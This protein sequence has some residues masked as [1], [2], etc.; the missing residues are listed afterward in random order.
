MNIVDRLTNRTETAEP[1][2]NRARRDM[3]FSRLRTEHP[4]WG[5]ENIDLSEVDFSLTDDE[6]RAEI[7][8]HLDITA[9]DRIAEIDLDA[10]VSPSGEHRRRSRRAYA[11]QVARQRRKGTHRFRRAQHLARIN[12]GERVSGHEK[13]VAQRAARAAAIAAAQQVAGS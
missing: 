7:A 6:T 11:R 5:E 13:V 3:L 4:E 1:A 2:E 8:K 9:E 10:I 12:K